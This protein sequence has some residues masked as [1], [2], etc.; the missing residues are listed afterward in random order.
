MLRDGFGF[1][2]IK[3]LLQASF[4]TKIVLQKQPAEEW[5]FCKFTVCIKFAREILVNWMRRGRFEQRNNVNRTAR[6]HKYAVCL[7]TITKRSDA[8]TRIPAPCSEIQSVFSI[9]PLMKCMRA[10]DQE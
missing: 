8:C 10:T 9:A 3:V 6:V 1:L 5:L 4:E 7:I 2:L